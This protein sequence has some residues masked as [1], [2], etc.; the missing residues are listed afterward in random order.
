MI[1]TIIPTYRRPKLLKRAIASVLRQ[2]YPHFQICVYDNASR[3]ETEEVVREFCDARVQYFCH[4]QNIGS[5]ANFQFGLERVTTPYFSFLS[6]DDFLL[7]HFYEQMLEAFAKKPECAFCAGDVLSL[8]GKNLNAARPALVEERY[9]P[10]PWGAMEVIFGLMPNWSGILFKKEKVHRLNTEVLALDID[11]LLR[12]AVDSPFFLTKEPCAVY[13]CNP[14]GITG[15][16]GLSLCYPSIYECVQNIIQRK[17]LAED[18]RTEF[19]HKMIAKLKRLIFF[20]GRRQLKQK[21]CTGAKE[22]AQ[23]LENVFRDPFLSKILRIAATLYKIPGAH[24]PLEA[25]QKMLGKMR[26]HN[27]V[28]TQYASLLEQELAHYE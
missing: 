17:D 26:A 27:S 21:D 28:P 19:E 12:V 3:D 16:A 13:T 23:I 25:L 20:E 6:D 9:F 5:N 2:T 11:F 15:K 7:P 4:P 1:T 24:A 14:Q 8:E 22:T 10:A 18:F